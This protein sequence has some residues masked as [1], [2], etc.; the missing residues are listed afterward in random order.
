M[1]LLPVLYNFSLLPPLHCNFLAL[2]SRPQPDLSTYTYLSKLECNRHVRP[3][4]S[5]GLNMA[6][7]SLLQLCENDDYVRLGCNL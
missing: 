1:L 3:V 7:I 4:R 5:S 2:K 6:L